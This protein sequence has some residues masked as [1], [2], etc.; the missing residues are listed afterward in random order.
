MIIK[1]KKGEVVFRNPELLAVDTK[2]VNLDRVSDLGSQ[3]ITME[4][5]DTLPVS[6]RKRTELD[7]AYAARSIARVRGMI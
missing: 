1:L 5:G 3:T 6:R 7:Q 2:M 4:N